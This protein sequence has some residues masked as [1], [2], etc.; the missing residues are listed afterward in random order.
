MDYGEIISSAFRVAWRNKSLWILGLFAVGWSN[1]SDIIDP[2]FNERIGSSG[3]QI[4]GYTLDFKHFAETN[5]WIL[6]AI[7]GLLVIYMLLFIILHC[8]CTPALIDGVN[9][10][11]RGGTYRLR[12]SFSTGLD[13]FWRYIGIN[14]LIMIIGI[15]TT[16][17]LIGPVVLLFV[18]SVP[19]G[20]L[21]LII[22]F[23]AFFFFIYAKIFTSISK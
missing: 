18:I 6:I 3:F 8:I 7:A 4:L 22:I 13:F 20:F 19:L 1:L 5:I 10:L 14:L 12:E 23:P 9:R 11:T 2:D 15:F 16:I 21:S 17:A